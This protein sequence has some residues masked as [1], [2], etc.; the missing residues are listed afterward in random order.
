MRA[1]LQ[2]NN[3]NLQ[4]FLH[5]TQKMMLK[6][7]LIRHDSDIQLLDAIPLLLFKSFRLS[8][9]LG[10][11]GRRHLRSIFYLLTFFHRSFTLDRSSSCL[12][13][14]LQLNSGFLLKVPF[15]LPRFLLFVFIFDLAQSD[16]RFHTGHLHFLKRLHLVHLAFT[17]HR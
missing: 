9:D 15:A 1:F 3:V 4:V 7:L 2:R 5:L 8:D 10:T 17:N 11:R 6:F 12:L 13:L 14:T 16:F